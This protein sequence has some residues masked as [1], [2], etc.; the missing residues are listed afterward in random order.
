VSKP[1][2]SRRPPRLLFVCTANLQRS[3]TAEGLFAGSRKC[4]ARSCGTSPY[5]VVPCSAELLRWADVVF[6]MEEAHR[7]SLAAR[8]PG[9]ADRRVVVLGIPDVYDRDDPALVV[10]LRQLIREL[11]PE[12]RA[13]LPPA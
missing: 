12:L 9:L 2:P 5:A 7:D 4:E 11:A 10:L 3:P 6:C 13:L 1:R 8:F